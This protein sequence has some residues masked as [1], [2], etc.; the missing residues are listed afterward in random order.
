[1]GTPL[2]RGTPEGSARFRREKSGTFSCSSGLDRGPGPEGKGADA[3]MK[4]LDPAD[5][6]SMTRVAY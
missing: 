6:R 4:S 5:R 3:V 1:M 2:D